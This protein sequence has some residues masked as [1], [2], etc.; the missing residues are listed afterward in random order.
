[1]D[2]NKTI[3]TF[4]TQ[5]L[6]NEVRLLTEAVVLPKKCDLKE[7]CLVSIQDMID[8]NEEK[9]ELNKNSMLLKLL[10]NLSNRYEMKIMIEKVLEADRFYYNNKN[11]EPK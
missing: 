2:K 1:M 7:R 10:F 5:R 6:T 11:N 4:H 8:T 3:R 9:S